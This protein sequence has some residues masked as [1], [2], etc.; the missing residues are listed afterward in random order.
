VTAGPIHT[1]PV[2]DLVAHDLSADC[3]CGPKAVLVDTDHGD[4]WMFVHHALDGRE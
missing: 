1:R 2:N 4:E 3:V